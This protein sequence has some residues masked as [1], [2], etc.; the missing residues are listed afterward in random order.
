MAETFEIPIGKITLTPQEDSATCW[1]ACY[2]MMYSYAGKS[3][4]DLDKALETAGKLGIDIK[5]A[6][7]RGLLTKDY[8]H[9]AMALGLQAWIGTG[10]YT[11]DYLKWLLELTQGPLWVAG[12]WKS[13]CHNI[14]VYGVGKDSVKVIDPWWE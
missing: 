1:Y 9:A 8:V 10:T 5:A 7:L 12:R 14:L 13:Y 2:R 11:C 6:K 4:G 3:K